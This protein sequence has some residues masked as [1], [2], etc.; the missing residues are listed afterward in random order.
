M[1]AETG[2]IIHPFN[3]FMTL[4]T[5]VSSVI[6]CCFSLPVRNPHLRR[7][8]FESRHIDAMRNAKEVGERLHGR[9]KERKDAR[10]GA[11]NWLSGLISKCV[12]N[13]LHESGCKQYGVWIR[14]LS[15][16]RIILRERYIPGIVRHVSYL[17][18]ELKGV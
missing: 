11:E 17:R 12:S 7:V 2:L 5:S 9:K 15:R 8:A 6:L 1:F 13:V 4:S 14:S 3:L 18:I 16:E 10:K